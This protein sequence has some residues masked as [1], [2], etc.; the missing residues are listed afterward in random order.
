MAG[1][2]TAKYCPVHTG[3]G[4]ETTHLTLRDEDRRE[5]AKCIA[6][7]I[8][9]DDIL[10]NIHRN[11]SN[12]ASCLSGVTRKD[13]HNIAKKY[14]LQ[15]NFTENDPVRKRKKVLLSSPLESSGAASEMSLSHLGNSVLLH[16]EL[17]GS[18]VNVITG[19]QPSYKQNEIWM[20]PVSLFTSCQSN[21]SVGY[22][23]FPFGEL[24][25]SEVNVTPDD[26]PSHLHVLAIRNPQE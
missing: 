3:H 13:L 23:V 25:G 8:S 18:E 20:N 9:F 2:V 15:K 4:T 19:I 14:H 10:D 5:L 22:S 6:E 26:Q 12:P 17:V 24:L 1:S 21:Y 7:G 16:G 11:S